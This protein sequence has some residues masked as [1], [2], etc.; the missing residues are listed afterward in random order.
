MLLATLPLKAIGVVSAVFLGAT[1]PTPGEALRA[2]SA[3]PTVEL[4]VPPPATT[5]GAPTALAPMAAL[6]EPVTVTLFDENHKETSIVVIGRDGSVDETND[7]EIRRLF[8][9]RRTG[10]QRQIDQRL[11]ALIA[12]LQLR[13]PGKTIDF[14]SGYRG[15]KEESKTSPHRAGR[16]LDLRIAG[17]RATEIRDYLW[18]EHRSVG[19]GYYPHEGF[20]HIDSR[21]KDIAWTETRGVNHYHPSWAGRA[22]RADRG[23]TARRSKRSRPNV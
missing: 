10:K 6:A 18:R 17:V 4:A 12:D 22:R 2:T 20:V 7:K 13:Y 15:H 14:V 9:C 19:V 1:Q 11:L 3:A 23:E 16:A 21:E 5:A 8:R